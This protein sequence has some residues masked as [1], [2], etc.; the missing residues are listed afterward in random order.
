LRLVLQALRTQ[1]LSLG[2]S[3]EGEETT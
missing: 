2:D 3:A 1:T